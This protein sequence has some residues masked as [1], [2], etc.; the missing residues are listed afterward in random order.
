MSTPERLRATTVPEHALLHHRT[1]PTTGIV[2]LGLSSFH[3][4]HLA[5][6]TARAVAAAGGDWGIYAYSLRS[7]EVPALL[8][9][10]DLLY[11]VVEIAPGSEDVAVPAIH[12]AAL[13]GT[14]DP[15]DVVHQI[16][17]APTRIVSITVTEA[18]YSIS[19]RTG[20]LDH[21]DPLVEADLGGAAPRTVVG[22]VVRGLQ[23]RATTHREP[24]TVLSCDNLSANGDRTSQLVHEFAA[25]LPSDERDE[26]LEYLRESVTFPNSMVDRIVPRPVEGHREMAAERLGVQDRAAVPAEPFTMWVLEDRFAG[27][28][29]AWEAAGAIFSTEVEAYELMKLRLLNGTHSLLAYVGAL[30]G[31]A[32]I[33]E[34]RGTGFIE[35]AA[36][37]V[38]TQEYLPTLTVPD[39]VCVDDYVEELF[40]RWS[41]SVLGHR[42]GQVGSDGSVKLPQRITEPLVEAAADSWT[43]PFISLTVASYLACLVPFPGFD[44]GPFAAEMTDPSRELLSELG[45]TSDGPDEVVRRFLDESGLLPPVLATLPGFSSQVTRYLSTIVTDGV[46]AAVAL[47]HRAPAQPEQNPKETR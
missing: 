37:S 17:A 5:V 2:H 16:G 12:T 9:E 26:L 10:Q 20:A 18:G 19:P 47:A 32:T 40:A 27:G 39:G 43:P 15:W 44:P 23:Q 8:G 45:A 30:A 34:A 38:L 41:N 35:A 29:P 1:V 14:T 13:G 36:R 3:R 25:R 24:I 6:Y 28:R 22:L 31:C 46:E 33:P 4:A 42:T 11:S 7:E 21:E